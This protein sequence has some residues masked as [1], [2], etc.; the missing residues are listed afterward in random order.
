MSDSIPLKIVTKKGKWSIFKNFIKAL[1]ANQDKEEGI[2]PLV[3]RQ[4]KEAKIAL[5]IAASLKLNSR[6][7]NVRVIQ[8]I[9]ELLVLPPYSVA[10]N[11]DR[12]TELEKQISSVDE[13][14]KTL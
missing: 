5:D 6:H 8:R 2:S 1:F 12:F 9:V 13:I 11:D 4:L 3:E 7:E 14:L 10:I